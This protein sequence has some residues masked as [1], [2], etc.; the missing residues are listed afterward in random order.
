MRVH[1]VVVGKRVDGRVEGLGVGWG[2]RGGRE[3]SG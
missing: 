1:C 2:D 3:M